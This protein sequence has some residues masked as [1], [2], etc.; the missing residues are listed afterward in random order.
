MGDL[1]SDDTA[2]RPAITDDGEKPRRQ[3]SGFGAFLAILVGLAVIVGGAWVAAYAFAGDRIPRNTTVAGVN[4][5]NLSPESARQKLTKQIGARE[6]DAIPVTVG[7][8]TVQVTPSKAGMALD[9]D[10]TVDKATTSNSWNPRDLWNHYT[11]GYDV[12]PVVTVDDAKFAK[13]VAQVNAKVGTPKKDGAV[14]FGKDGVQVTD[15]VMGKGVEAEALRS[16][17]ETALTSPA[18]ADVK[19]ELPLV[20]DVP[21][22]DSTDVQQAVTTFANPAMAAP[23]T[24]MFGKSPVQLSPSQYAGA[25]SLKPSGG[26]LVPAVDKAAVAALI[27][28][29]TASRKDAPQDAT[30]TIRNGKPVVVPAKPGVSFDPTQAAQI[31]ESL[32]TKPDGQR[33]GTI[34]SKVAEPKIS[35]AE[36]TSWGIKEKISTFT[37]Y[38]PYAEYRNINIGRA[39][40]LVNGTVL[41]PGDTFSLNGIVGERTK[42]NGFTEGWTIQDGVF[43]SDLGG[44]VSQM[45]TTTFN[46]MFFAGLQDVEHKPHSL[47]ISRYPIGREATVAWGSVDLRFKNNTKYGVLVRAAVKPST[48]SSQGVVTVSMWS[49]KIWDITTSTGPRYAST[50]FKKITDT[51]GNCE[52]TSGANGFQIDVKRYFHHVGSAAV[53]KTENFHTTYNPQNQVTCKGPVSAPD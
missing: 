9:I 50:P 39:A 2:E 35:T 49:T 1:F 6:K 15:A 24:L 18:D 17:L 46:A 31:F 11:G 53:V 8:Q 33:T 19:T 52:T 4:I 13:T 23:V 45:A 20:D 10:A 48:P 27:N 44:G 5:G 34:T 28:A 21:D 3:R 26:S 25:L 42:A 16:G 30:V 22:I 43:K 38:F 47:Y 40:E 51:S 7:D 41:K 37:T 14:S 12:D 29:G 36:A 32:L